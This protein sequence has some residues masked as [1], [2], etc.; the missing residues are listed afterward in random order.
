MA[1]FVI[2]N[3]YKEIINNILLSSLVNLSFNMSKNFSILQQY[4]S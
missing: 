1:A 4:T 3:L 2:H